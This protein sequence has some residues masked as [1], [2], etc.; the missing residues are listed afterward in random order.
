MRIIEKDLKNKSIEIEIEDIEDLWHLYNLIDIGDKVCGYTMREIRILKKDGSEERCG[1]HRVYMCIEVEDLQ[2]QRFTENLRIRGKIISC[3]EEV[4][5]KGQYHTFSI[6]VGD[7]IKIIKKLWL[8]FHEERLSLAEKKE[9]QNA[10]IVTIDEEEAEIF[11]I[12]GDAIS[13]L[14]S[15]N[16]NLPGK[17]L[18]NNRSSE[19]RNFLLSITKEI[20]RIAEREKA[21]III[22]GPGFTKNDLFSI[23]KEKNVNAILEDA[24]SIGFSGVREIIKRGALSKIFKNSLIVRDLK[25]IDELLFRLAKKPSMVAYGLNEVK[26]VAEQGA[27]DS[28][29][30]SEKIFKTASFEERILLE[31]IC[32]NVEKYGGK[33]YFISLDNEKGIQLFNLGGIAA[34]LRFSVY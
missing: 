22:G 12:R 8:S 29:L 19:R 18:E 25:L 10:L 33:V 24:S 31:E 16:S 23:L 14:I 1:K 7:C 13:H 21:H 30:I 17:Y 32:K 5:A 2:F 26:K 3:P 9:K 28:L 20:I 11:L 15:I 34:L 27:V 4:H 6:K